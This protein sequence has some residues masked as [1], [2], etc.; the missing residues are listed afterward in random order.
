MAQTK[1]PNMPV[2]KFTAWSF[3]I[4]AGACPVLMIIKILATMEY[5]SEPY[6]HEG[7]LETL[8]NNGIFWSCAFGVLTIVFIWAAVRVSRGLDL[9]T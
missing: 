9:S 2:R 5:L 8:R 3:M 4:A 1:E 7:Q 6:K